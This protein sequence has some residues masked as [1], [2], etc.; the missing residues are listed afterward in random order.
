MQDTPPTSQ[1]RRRAGGLSDLGRPITAL[2]L[3]DG[4]L[5]AVQALEALARSRLERN[6]LSR[7]LQAEGRVS[8]E[9]LRDALARSHGAPAVPG[10][11]YLQI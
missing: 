11:P 5:D 4:A 10:K 3:E 9:Q 8:P 6:P 2:L 7:L 1:T